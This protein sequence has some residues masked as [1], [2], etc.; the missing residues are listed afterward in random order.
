MVSMVATMS[1]SSIMSYIQRIV[2]AL[3][4]PVTCSKCNETFQFDSQY[5]VHYNERHSEMGLG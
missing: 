3:A 5:V 2:T 4:L 1:W